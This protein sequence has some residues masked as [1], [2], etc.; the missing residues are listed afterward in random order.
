MSDSLLKT[1]LESNF[2]FFVQIMKSDAAPKLADPI[3]NEV[4]VK[5]K[6]N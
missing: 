3:L 4:C 1:V 6:K 5:Y 2:T